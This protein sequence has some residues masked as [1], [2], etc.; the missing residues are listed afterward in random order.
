ME[1]TPEQI[2]EQITEKQRELQE[3]AAN[4]AD[5]SEMEALR[6]DLQS[7]KDAKQSAD[8]AA[9]LEKLDEQIKIVIGQGEEITKL[10]EEAARSGGFRTQGHALA[11]ALDEKKEEIAAIR[12]GAQKAPLVISFK[13]AVVESVEATIGSGSTQNLI[14]Q[15]TG[16]IST[17]RKREL[18]YLAH[19]SVGSIG[20]SR[21]LWVEETDEQGAPTFIGEGDGKAQASVL[22]VEQTM[23]VKKVAVYCKMTQEFFEDLPQ[24]VSYVLNNLGRRLDIKVEDG[25][26]SGPGTGDELK[27]A[28]EYATAFSAPASLALNVMNANELDALEALALQCKNAFGLPTAC[29]ITPSYMSKI[30][31]I[32]DENGRPVWKDY[33]TITGEMVISG[34]TIVE[35]NALDG[36]DIDFLGGDTKVINVLYRSQMDFR[37]GLDGNDFT[38]NKQTAVLEK[39]LVQFVSANDTPVLIKGDFATAIEALDLIPDA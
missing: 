25:L 6:A 18:R 34:M 31:L 10:K 3:A 11:A 14:T 7:L 38:Q 8:Q 23:S 28:D 5:R 39:R 33:V 20:T 29:W 9:I 2:L 15:N 17:I 1:R 21:A 19:V 32:K 26:V 4:K 16:I 35:T 37:Y 27:G 13:D 12:K 24:F 30:K 22:Y 36:L